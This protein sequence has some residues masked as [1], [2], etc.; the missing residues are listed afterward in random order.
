LEIQYI[1][2]DKYSIL[3]DLDINFYHTGRH[4]FHYDGQTLQL[5]D[6]QLSVL[7]F[8]EKVTGV[9]A[10]A[11]PNGSGKSSICGLMFEIA[12]TLA[13]GILGYNILFKGILIIADHILHHHEMTLSNTESLRA[14]GYTVKE[15]TKTPLESIQKEQKIDFFKT[16]FIYFSNTLDWRS[17]IHQVNL[18]NYSTEALLTQ[19]VRTATGY[20]PTE[21]GGEQQTPDFIGAYFEGQGYRHTRF[22]LNFSGHIPFPAPQTFILKSTYSGNNRALNFKSL[23]EYDVYKPFDELEQ[24]ILLEIY[25][26]YKFPERDEIVQ[27]NQEAFKACA[28]HLYRFNILMAVAVMKKALPDLAQASAFVYEQKVPPEFFN[29][30]PQLEELL[31]VHGELLKLG[32]FNK[33]WEPYLHYD[34]NKYQYWR[35]FGLEWFKIENTELSRTHLKR[36]MDLEESVINEETNFFKRLS[37]YNMH[38]FNSSGEY[39]YYSLFSRLYD[40]IQRNVRGSDMR[41]TMILVLDEADIGYHPVWKKKLLKWVM[42]FLNEEFNPYIFQVIF[43]THSPYLLSDLTTEHL[44]LLNNLEGKTQVVPSGDRLTFGANINELLAD[45]FFMS[46]GLI[47][48]FARDKIQKVIDDLNNWRLSK[49][50][51]GVLQVPADVRDN[52]LKMIAVVGDQIVRNKLFEMYWDLFRD[53]AALDNE[54]DILN[55]RITYLKSLKK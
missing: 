14:Q 3:K 35:F 31:I 16:G 4:R 36:L 26:A 29:N 13:N 24:N 55:E 48:D 7:D 42:D 44:L 12:A 40:A 21:W 20:L 10:I 41:E 25:P 19:D 6:N 1:W 30:L 37:N 15:F 11:G 32:R 17:D 18:A 54:I 52:S 49:E 53:Q 46:D 5:L 39:N 47:G 28:L 8:G 51:N 38:P 45:S 9:T 27:V 2:A 50:R 23:F 22:Y 33:E 34:K 43:T